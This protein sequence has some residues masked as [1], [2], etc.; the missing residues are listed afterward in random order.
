[1]AAHYR[2]NATVAQVS[3][4]TPWYGVTVTVRHAVLPVGALLVLGLG[5]YLYVEVRAQPAPVVARAR[6][7]APAPDPAVESAD[8]SVQ[9]VASP[10]GVPPVA[11]GAAPAPEAQRPTEATEATE[12]VRPLGAVPRG[13][14]AVQDTLTGHKLDEVMAEA[15][16][17][18]DRS[19]YE[20]AKQIAARVLA[21]EPTN[22]RMLRI[23]VSASCIDGDSTVAQAH[24]TRLPALDQEQ[25]RVRCARYGVFFADK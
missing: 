22:V 15:N 8:P 20:E 5:V 7:E 6:P 9:P 25:M 10:H 23:V 14:P 19:D 17:A 4:V 13:V 11:P 18:Y 1:M 2:F 12:A 3:A 24:Y 21:Q 16:K